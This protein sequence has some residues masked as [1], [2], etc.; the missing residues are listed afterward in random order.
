MEIG[1]VI[2]ILEVFVGIIGG[3]PDTRIHDGRYCWFF[4]EVGRLIFAWE[5]RV[6]SVFLEVILI[7][8]EL[9]E[10]MIYRV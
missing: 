2:Y 6:Y 9:T 8:E 7:V 4:Y 5:Y 3:T 1:L 10:L